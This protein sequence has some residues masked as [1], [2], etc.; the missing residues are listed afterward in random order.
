MSVLSETDASE[1]E[2]A[3]K[4]KEKIVQKKAAVSEETNEKVC[5]L[6]HMK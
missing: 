4:K 3:L 6:L 1:V 5:T 2:G